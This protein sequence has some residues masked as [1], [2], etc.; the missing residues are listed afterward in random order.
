MYE[1]YGTA[2]CSAGFEDGSFTIFDLKSNKPIIDKKVFKDPI[3]CIRNIEDKTI[4]GATGNFIVVLQNEKSI[5]KHELKESGINDISFKD[6]RIYSTAGWDSKVRVFDL[7]KNVPLA[8]LKYHSSG[9]NSVDYKDIK[10]VSGS[11]DHRI[12][13]W[14]LEFKKKQKEEK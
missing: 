3:L 10:L 11:K 6:E 12:A 2:F 8:I 5:A 1:K 7:K 9:V 4:L 14:N 13:L